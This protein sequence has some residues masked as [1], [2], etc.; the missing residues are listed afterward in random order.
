[1]KTKKTILN[2]ITDII[3]L[4]IISVLGIYKV[5]LF[6]Q[7]LG[8]S[9]LGLYQMYNNLIVYV[10]FIDGGLSSALLFSLYKPNTD[11]DDKKINELLSGGLTVFSQIGMYVFGASF[12]VSLLVFFLIKD[13]PFTYLYVALTFFI[14]ALSSV[15]E[16]FF[17]PYNAL[18]EVKEK[19]HIY[20]LITQIGQITI[21]IIEIVLLLN[22]VEFIYILMS[23]SIVKIITKIIEVIICKKMFPNVNVREEKKDY[24]FKKLLGSLMF[25]KVNGLV[26]SNIDSLIISSF[27]GL[28]YVAIYSAYNYII[29]M[30]KKILGKLSSS[31]TAI[32]G[33]G[34]LEDKKRMYEI[35]H[36]YNSALFFIAIVVCVPLMYAINGFINMYYDGEIVTSS[37]LAISFA[38]LLFVYII[39]LS[40]TVYIDAAGLYKETKTC[41]LTDTIVNL[42]LSLVLTYFFGI[43]GVVI[44]TIISSLLSE[45]VMKT[46][47][48]HQYVFKKS[49]VSYFVKNIKFY[50]I[51]IID[52]LINYYLVSLFSINSLIIWLGFFT[53]LTILNFILVLLIFNMIKE[54][55]F[56]SRLLSVI[57]K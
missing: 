14:F 1:M 5:K 27:L 43:A 33:N 26:G 8:D 30:L 3:P 45:Y 23:H 55:A 48:V 52:L 21:S 12:V 15:I 13:S 17:V 10:T 44:A 29:N 53:G 50:I 46:M 6:L 40:S 18:L 25:H 16:Y 56:Y 32:I 39:K 49:S 42:I 47:I 54:G 2:L 7:I 38:L 24:H 41:S 20:N 11:K 19:K 37:I 36:E 9:T 35:Y 22:H 28:G 34:L 57:K 51:F 31:M 4:L